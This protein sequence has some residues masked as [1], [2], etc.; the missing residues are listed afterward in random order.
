MAPVVAHECSIFDSRPMGR[1]TVMRL[2]ENNGDSGECGEWL[3]IIIWRQ[4]AHIRHDDAGMGEVDIEITREVAGIR[5]HGHDTRLWSP[6]DTIGED[7]VPGEAVMT[8][9]GESWSLTSPFDAPLVSCAGS[10]WTSKWQTFI[11]ESMMRF[12]LRRGSQSL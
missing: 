2:R 4:M 3:P 12:L 11:D 7:T 1:M 9:R 10:P 6:L 5:R 8:T